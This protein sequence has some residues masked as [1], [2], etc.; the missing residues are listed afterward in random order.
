[1]L[2]FPNTNILVSKSKTTCVFAFA[3]HETESRILTQT[4]KPDF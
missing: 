3:C 2:A 4:M 1:M